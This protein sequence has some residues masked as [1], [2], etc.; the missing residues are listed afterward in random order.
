MDAKDKQTL[1]AQEIQ[2]L[3]IGYARFKNSFT[4]LVRNNLIL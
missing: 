4:K 1:E 3:V 2:P